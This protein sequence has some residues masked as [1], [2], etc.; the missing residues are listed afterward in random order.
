MENDVHI[1]LSQRINLRLILFSIVAVALIGTPL[2]WYID[3]SLANGIK[4][5]GDVTEVDLKAMSLFP[6][7]QVRG[8]LTDVPERFRDL[9]GKKVEMVGEMYLVN[10]AG[11]D[12]QRFDLVYSISKCC[13]QGPPLIQH[14]V[15]AKGRDGKMVPY[16]QG[17]VKVTGTLHVDVKQGLDRVESVYQLDVDSVNQV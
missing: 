10:F 12:V 1:P 13:G 4:V 6:F 11:D 3:Y 14:F 9:N 5:H 7:D 15:Q 16:Y 17:L 2:Y 8:T